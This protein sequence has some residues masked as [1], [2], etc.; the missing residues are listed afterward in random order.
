[1]FHVTL[2]TIYEGT[3][4]TLITYIMYKEVSCIF[5]LTSCNKNGSG[6][7]A[8]RGTAPLF[9]KEKLAVGPRSRLTF[10]IFSFKLSGGWDTEWWAA[11]RRYAPVARPLLSILYPRPV[12][13][14]KY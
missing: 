2:S 3:I 1:M 10:F 4:L 7:R 11:L 13:I 8:G 14:N 5:T 9:L 6:K 12:M